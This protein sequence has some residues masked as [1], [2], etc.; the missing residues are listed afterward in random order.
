[1]AARSTTRN[2]DHCVRGSSAEQQRQHGGAAAAEDQS[3]DRRPGD[4]TDAAIALRVEVTVI[5]VDV[6]FD[7]AHAGSDTVGPNAAGSVARERSRSSDAETVNSPVT[8]RSE[9]VSVT[10]M[11]STG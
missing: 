7:I 8:S 4:E 3:D 11:R 10:P 9:T 6:P 2:G 5:V 1:A